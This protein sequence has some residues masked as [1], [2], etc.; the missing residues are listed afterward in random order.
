MFNENYY[1]T[2]KMAWR[3]K[4]Q[5]NIGI[6]KDLASHFGG[7]KADYLKRLNHKLRVKIAVS[8]DLYSNHFRMAA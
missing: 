8:N 4:A 7:K 1:L 3:K 6:A 2:N 5:L